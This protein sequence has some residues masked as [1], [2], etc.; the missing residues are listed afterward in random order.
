[1]NTK[2]EMDSKGVGNPDGEL[3]IRRSLA[4]D[5]QDMFIQDVQ[6]S[7]QNLADG[8]TNTIQDVRS[9]G[10]RAWECLKGVR[11]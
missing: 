6:Q 2:P 9:A 7:G 3:R 11:K 4:N 5:T 10:Q 8:V 1:V